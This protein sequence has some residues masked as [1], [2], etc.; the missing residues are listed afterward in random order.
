MKKLVPLA[1]VALAVLAVPFPASA[2]RPN[3][4]ATIV[5]TPSAPVV[6]DSL[7]FSGCGYE[8]GVG[9]GVSLVTPEA[10]VS[11]G[12][13]AGADGCFSTATTEVLIVTAAG[14]YT[15]STYPSGKHR[16]D[17]TVS[18]VVAP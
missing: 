16:P 10:Y 4:D 14:D 17:A 15:A 7:V 11:F 13:P 18:F 6:G 12:A 2:V 9:V 5:V 1:L 8:P 3:H